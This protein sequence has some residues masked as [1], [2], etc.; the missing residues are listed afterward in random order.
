[1]STEITKED[2]IKLERRINSKKFEKDEL[3]LEKREYEQE[4]MEL[5]NKV[6]SKILS[7]NEYLNVTKNQEKT[8]AKILLIEKKIVALNQELISLN[9]TKDEMKNQIPEKFDFKDLINTV[10][11]MKNKHF[12]LSRDLQ[13]IAQLR[14]MN[15]QFSD[16]LQKL[17]EYIKTLEK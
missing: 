10:Q 11:S 8:R 15:L 13:R 17:I 14:K 12:E 5:K 7:Q 6:R 9:T 1:M 2:L 3:T 16:E 4:M